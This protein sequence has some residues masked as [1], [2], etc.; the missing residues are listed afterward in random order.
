MKSHLVTA[1]KSMRGE[2]WLQIN[3]T[4]KW[5]AR[6]AGMAQEERTRFARQGYTPQLAGKARVP[7]WTPSLEFP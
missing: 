7:P 5:R 2:V 4:I 6:W 1:A 3:H